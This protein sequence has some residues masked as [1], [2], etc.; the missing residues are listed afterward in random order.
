MY[1][2]RV[3]RPATP[4]LYL[5][6][7][8]GIFDSYLQLSLGVALHTFRPLYYY[9]NVATELMGLVYGKYGGRSD[10]FPPGVASYDKGFCP[11]VS[12]D[13]FKMATESELKPMCMHENTMVFMFESSTVFTLTDYAMKHTG[14]LH[15]HE[16][17]MWDNLRG[18]FVN[19]IPEVN[20]ALRDASLPDM[21]TKRK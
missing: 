1:P 4:A 21:E 15:E 12:Y 8:H 6:V 14:K 7:N 2:S 18:Q 3:L 17:K 16:P 13:E 20:T 9:R 11:H 19:H 5:P 10:K